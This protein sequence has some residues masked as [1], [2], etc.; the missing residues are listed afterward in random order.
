MLSLRPRNFQA[1]AGAQGRLFE[2]TCQ[3]VLQQAGFVLAETHLFIA[4]AGVN[5]DFIAHNADEV[6]FYITCKGSYQG[7]RPGAKRTDTLKKA[8]AESYALH[9]QGFGPIL[10][11]TSHLPDTPSG[12]AL[13]ASVDPDVLFD[14]I[15]ATHGLKR[16]QWLARASETQL[17]ADVQ[18]RHTRYLL[19]R[20]V[21]RPWRTPREVASE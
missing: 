12:L 21:C 17:R 20:P 19:A 13:L 5:V 15:D 16:L 2:A 6:A 1:A 7:E 4:E 3:M 9:A 10:L 8:I 14:A 18:R 11:L